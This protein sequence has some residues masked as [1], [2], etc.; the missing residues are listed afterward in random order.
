MEGEWKW[1]KGKG[2]GGGGIA[3]K[4]IIED[5]GP[6]G[7][8]GGTYHP[9]LFPCLQFGDAEWDAKSLVVRGELVAY[10]FT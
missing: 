6:S 9:K 8:L 3:V 4:G 7:Q 2:R 10:N 5:R 1:S